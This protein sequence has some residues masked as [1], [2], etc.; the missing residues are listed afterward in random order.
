[1]RFSVI[2]VLT[3]IAIVT[4]VRLKISAYAL[5]YSG[6]PS[7]NTW[8]WPFKKHIKIGTGTLSTLPIK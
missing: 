3:L 1:M 8:I 6:P 5:Y 7:C 2:G 4:T